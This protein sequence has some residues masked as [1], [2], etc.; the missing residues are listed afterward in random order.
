LRFFVPGAT[1]KLS[2]VVPL[3]GEKERFGKRTADQIKARLPSE[4]VILIA[5][6]NA[7]AVLP[8]KKPPVLIILIT[9]DAR[10]VA[11]EFC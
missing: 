9:A 11:L 1:E 2:S 8:R 7:V 6:G 10:P 3:V 5:R 4:A